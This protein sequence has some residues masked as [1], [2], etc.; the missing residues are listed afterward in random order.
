[1]TFK[2]PKFWPQL[3]KSPSPSTPAILPTPLNFC[4]SWFERCSIG[5]KIY[6]GYG[7]ALAVA[8]TGVTGGLFLGQQAYALVEQRREDVLQEVSLISQFQIQLSHLRLHRQKLT[9][10]RLSP[11]ELPNSV[12]LLRDHSIEIKEVWANLKESYLDQTVPE[13]EEETQLLQQLIEKYDTTLN[14][15]IQQT[16]EELDLIETA[17]PKLSNPEQLQV[18]LLSPEDRQLEQQLEALTE[19]LEALQAVAMTEQVVATADLEHAQVTLLLV[20]LISIG[21]SAAIASLLARTISRAIAQPINEVSSIARRVTEESDFSLRAAVYAQDETAVLA[22]ALNHLI[23]RVKQLLD[24]QEVATQQTLMQNEK[25]TSLVRMVAGVAHEINNPINF[26]YGNL[27]H[28]E[29][30]STDLLDLIHA[31]EASVAPLPLSVEEKAED[32]D[33]PFLETDLPKLL[34]SMRV[35]AERTRQIVLS[36]KN[37]SHLDEGEAHPVDLHECLDSTLLILNNRTKKGVSIVRSYGDI[38]AVA[39]YAG[40]LYQV[41]MNLFVNA[42]DALEEHP[43]QKPEIIIRTDCPQA[44]TVRVQVLDNGPGI[45]PD[46]LSRIFETFF[47]TKP[48]GIGTGLGLAIT[49]QIIEEKH[50]GQLSCRSTLGQGTEFTLE[51]PICPTSAAKPGSI[52]GSTPASGSAVTPSTS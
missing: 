2:A 7:C 14:Q 17:L 11:N 38:P 19:D 33:L 3:Q 5:R 1:M 23:A 44:H 28:I 22:T 6:L 41:F 31:F 37:F 34:Q 50:K 16:R 24:E 21:L 27:R 4:Q 10:S 48:A 8:L 9:N 18:A 47:T 45:A 43:P 30:Y 29:I 13:S 35:G 36:L 42:L 26:I 15:Y 12:A 20:L 46:H 25:M 51:L 39:G 32:I 52:N 40:S 49:R